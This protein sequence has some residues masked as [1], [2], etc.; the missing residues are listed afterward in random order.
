L[1]VGAATAAHLWQNGKI[2]VW[3]APLEH[4]TF[5][6]LDNDAGD[7]TNT[8]VYVRTPVRVQIAAGTFTSIVRNIYGALALPAFLGSDVAPIHGIANL[9]VPDGNYFWLATWGLA[10]IAQGEPLSLLV[11]SD[12]YFSLRDGTGW[13][14]ASAV[15]TPAV[16]P[17]N[18]QFAGRLT[19][20]M[21]GEAAT[22]DANIWLMLDP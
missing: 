18:P 20:N 17:I 9:W 19:M 4:Q 3:Q 12:I 8:R 13:L 15:S 7:G 14:S 5:D 1:V 6:I 11:G 16:P 10:Q 21:D 2:T 22:G